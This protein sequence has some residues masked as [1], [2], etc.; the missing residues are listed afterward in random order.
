MIEITLSNILCNQARGAE[1]N[2]PTI[3]H[4]DTSGAGNFWTWA[5]KTSS[6]NTSCVSDRQST[7]RKNLK[8]N[9]T[10]LCAAGIL[11]EGTCRAQKPVYTP[12][13]ASFQCSNWI[14]DQS[15]HERLSTSI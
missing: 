2:N 9:N 11:E 13:I 12:G 4:S 5:S 14:G 1:M 8:P 10:V 6:F 7:I 3:I 15:D